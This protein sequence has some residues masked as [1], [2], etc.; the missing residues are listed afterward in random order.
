MEEYRRKRDFTVLGDIELCAATREQFAEE[1]FSFPTAPISVAVTF[2]GVPGVVLAR[3]DPEYAEAV[4]SSTFAAMDGMPL[5]R[6]AKKGGI[7]C[8]R[9]AGPDV[10][11]L[12]LEESVKRGKT[13]YFYG[14]QSDE[15]LQKLKINL[16]RNYPGIQIAGMYSPPFRPL[17][18]EED[19]K[20]VRAINALS[21]D[22]LWVGL[23]APKQEK[24]MQSHRKSI[25][26]TVMLGVGAAF[27]FFSG[28]VHRAPDWMKEA[29]LEWLYRLSREPGRLWRRYI[30]GG[31]KW[32]WYRMEA[33]WKKRKR[34]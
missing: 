34:G 23:G 4:A 19:E 13:H 28:H 30:P 6:M 5:V 32:I 17:T 15:V 7:M 1:V 31:M 27:N 22:F 21:P 26:G 12:I 16:E 25:H 24:W 3:E 11:D 10:M 18:A 14:G 9:C 20:I 33:A 2:V 29:G 8:E